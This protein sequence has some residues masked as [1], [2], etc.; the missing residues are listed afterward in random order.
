MVPAGDY[1][2]DFSDP[3]AKPVSVSVADGGKVT[4]DCSYYAP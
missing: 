2:I 4:A 1:R 3:T